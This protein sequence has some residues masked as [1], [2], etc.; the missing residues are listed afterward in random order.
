M[1]DPVDGTILSVARAAAESAAGAPTLAETVTWALSAAEPR[2]CTRRSSCPSSPARAWSTRAGEGSCSSCRHWP[3]SS[4]GNGPPRR[5]SSSARPSTPQRVGSTHGPAASEYGYEVQYLLDAAAEAVPALRDR[6]AALGGSVAVVGT[7]GGVWNVHVH[8]R[9]H[10]C[11]HR[12]RYRG[13][14]AAPDQRRPV[15]RRRCHRSRRRRR[16]YRP[17]KRPPGSAFRNRRRGGRARATGS[18]TC[19]SAKGWASSRSERRGELPV[20]AVLDAVLATAA[21]EVVLL[22]NAERAG[23]GQRAGRARRPGRSASGSRSCRPA[24]PCRVWPRSPCTTA[25]AASTRT[26]SPWPRPR[27]RRG[28]PR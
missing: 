25:P 23:A 24:R 28:S 26:S 8:S 9:R 3:R 11:G 20:E 21:A 12:G 22:P 2:C 27:R 5:R 1:R 10:R 16:P 7:G 18:R 13:G 15:V 6:L 14:P 4:P 19:S 17:R